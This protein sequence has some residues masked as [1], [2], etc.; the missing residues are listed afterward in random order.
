METVKMYGR[1]YTFSDCV[2][3][4][5]DCF[6]EVDAQLYPMKEWMGEYTYSPSAVDCE[7]LRDLE[8]D[9]DTKTDVLASLEEKANVYIEFTE[10]IKSLLSAAQ[11]VLKG[12]EA[13]ITLC[14]DYPDEEEG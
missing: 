6:V 10:N 4:S 13:A 5:A 3:F 2:G 7:S 8:L 11:D 1:E 14:E 12:I 9:A